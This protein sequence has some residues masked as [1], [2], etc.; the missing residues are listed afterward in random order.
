MLTS[1]DPALDPQAQYSSA[2]G[3]AARAATAGAVVMAVTAAAH[4]LSGGGLPDATALVL[5]AALTSLLWWS[6]HRRGASRWR[7]VLVLVLA[8]PALHVLFTLGG[9]H[10]AHL[11]APTSMPMPTSGHGHHAHEV[12]RMPATMPD[13]VDPSVLDLLHLTPVMLGGHLAALV[14]SA[15]LVLAPRRAM[16]A[17]ALHWRALWSTL[18]HPALVPAGVSLRR[19]CTP[20][21][22]TPGVRTHGPAPVRG[23]PRARSTSSRTTR[24]A[25]S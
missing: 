1:T 18:T 2:A 7:A 16:R 3:D 8:Q 20:T 14:V 9:S 12:I 6:V 13:A 24:R 11:P 21:I 4:V 22:H 5:V 25:R 15:L 17:I 10:A 23:P 19:P